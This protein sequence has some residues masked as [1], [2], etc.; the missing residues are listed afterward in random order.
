MRMMVDGAAVALPLDGRSLRGLVVVKELFSPDYSDY[1]P[2]LL[3]VSEEAGVISIPLDYPELH[4]YT[5]HLTDENS[6][7]GAL[8][9]VYAVGRNSGTF[10][11]LRFGFTESHYGPSPTGERSA[12]E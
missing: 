7:I 2:P 9:R 5:A 11:R 12:P 8:D 3:Q 4:M 1:T 10:P 6:L